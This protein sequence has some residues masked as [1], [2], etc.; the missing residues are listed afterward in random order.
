MHFITLL[1]PA[2]YPRVRLIILF[3]EMASAV[4][5]RVSFF[6]TVRDR[7]DTG[8]SDQIPGRTA[9]SR[10]RLRIW[11]RETVSAAQS[12]VS[13][14]VPSEIGSTRV[15]AIRSRAARLILVHAC[16]FGLA[17]RFRQSRPASVFFCTVRDRIDTGNSIYRT[18]NQIPGR[19]ATVPTQRS[20]SKNTRDIPSVKH[21]NPKY[22]YELGN[23]E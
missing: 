15:R 19:T 5:S 14:F 7:I 3:R 12:H 9:L 20:G 13:F 17:T 2:P 22:L 10:A 4:P 16:E 11:S 6:C 8:M 1:A 18:S 23:G 21:Q